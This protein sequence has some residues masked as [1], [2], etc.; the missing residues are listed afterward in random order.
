HGPISLHAVDQFVHDPVIVISELQLFSGIGEASAKR[1]QDIGQASRGGQGSGGRSDDKETPGLN[2]CSWRKGEM[3]RV[4]QRPSRDV[5]I[6]TEL[7]FQLNPFEFRLVC[8]RV[9]HDFI[10]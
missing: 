10:E 2:Y 7:V 3:N 9:K 4:V 8:H 1:A 5:Y 6:D